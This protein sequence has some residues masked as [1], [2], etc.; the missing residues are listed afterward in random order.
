M[1]KRALPALAVAL[2]LILSAAAPAA[3]DPFVKV[4][5]GPLDDGARH[6]ALTAD[7]GFL[8][9]GY[10]GY[11]AEPD[12]F[13]QDVWVLRLDAAGDTLWTRTFGTPGT[14]RHD[15]GRCGTEIAGGDA[16]VCG[17]WSAYRDTTPID[18]SG[19]PF[20]MRLGGLD[21][22][23]AWQWIFDGGNPEVR[24]TASHV[25]ENAD[26]DIVACGARRA[27]GFTKK[28]A[29]SIQ[30]SPEGEDTLEVIYPADVN[31]QAW[32]TSIRQTPWDDGY[33]M[34]GLVYPPVVE[35]KAR[36]QSRCYLIKADAAGD[37]LWTRAFELTDRNW[38]G[39]H[40]CLTGDGGYALTGNRNSGIGAHNEIYIL[41]TDADGNHEWDRGYHNGLTCAGDAVAA[42]PD[43]GL[44]VAGF[45]LLPET[46]SRDAFLL[47][48][49]ALGDTVWV[50]HYAFAEGRD[51][52]D[53]AFSVQV[54]P[55]GFVL[56]GRTGGPDNEGSDVLVLRT[57]ERGVLV[58]VPGALLSK[59]I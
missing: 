53:R 28:H 47:K 19:D 22:E 9:T 16:V 3:A 23:P 36:G 39:R 5:G 1:R 13:D 2:A 20:V 11:P 14:L 43:G 7:G 17:T 24:G 35:E 52:V 25:I 26:G 59:I 27:L 54:L 4:Y 57:D 12:S 56:A 8:V 55:D 51:Y 58:G 31:Q 30:F 10:Y 15:L 21:G 49:D 18:L 34:S 37:T 50:R 42:T 45:V 33:V 40:I 38:E 46:D 48:T 32:A 44:V 29:F 6:I 41:K